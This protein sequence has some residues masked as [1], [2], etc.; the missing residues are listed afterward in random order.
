MDAQRP[1]GVLGVAAGLL[2]ACGPEPGG[3]QASG[4]GP[5]G[6]RLRRK[7]RTYRLRGNG[8]ARREWRH[9]R[10][11]DG[12]AGG[13]RFRRNQHYFDRVNAELEQSTGALD[14]WSFS[15]PAPDGEFTGATGGTAPS[16]CEQT[17]LSGRLGGQPFSQTSYGGEA[18]TD[19]GYELRRE[20]GSGLD[21][22]IY[23]IG[24]ENESPSDFTGGEAHATRGGVVL[25]PEEGPLPGS[26]VCG[27]DSIPS[28]RQDAIRKAV[29]F[30]EGRHRARG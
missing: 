29:R 8:R 24:T 30:C 22:L 21:G 16:P 10:R 13:S 19:R 23:F 20:F 18:I 28:E 7:R 1:G 4:G 25:M 9:G 2:V 27:N 5:F 14:C 3:A 6:W 11:R 26:F 17:T 15:E 12:W